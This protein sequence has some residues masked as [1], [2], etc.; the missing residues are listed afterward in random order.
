MTASGMTTKDP[1]Q[2][3][4]GH[5]LLNRF[6][7]SRPL[8]RGGMGDV[9]KAHDRDLGIDIAL[10]LLHPALASAPAQVEFLKNECRLARRLTHPHIVQVY[11]FHRDR[12]TVFISMA[13]VDGCS[14]DDWIRQG[15]RPWD[16]R[17]RPLVPIARALDFVHQQG[18]VHRDVKTGNIL[19]DRTDRSRLTDF[20]IAGVYRIDADPSTRHTGGSQDCMSPQQRRGLP[21]HPA[22]DI[23]S[24]GILLLETLAPGDALANRP[25]GS[26]AFRQALDSLPPA[27]A[28]LTDMIA[29][30]LA[31]RREERPADMVAVA[32]LMEALLADQTRQTI[33]PQATHAAQE[34]VADAPAAP[35]IRPQPF[36]APDT[37][38]K[39]PTPARSWRG[40]V[41][42]GLAALLLVAGG[43][44]LLHYLA[45]NPLVVK[46]SPEARPAAPPAAGTPPPVP[47]ATPEPPAGDEPAAE[48]ALADWRQALGELEAMGGPQWAPEAFAA[49][50]SQAQ[51]AD[52]AF[53]QADYGLAVQ[54]YEAAAEEARRLAATAPQ[55]LT[56]LLAEGQSALEQGDGPRSTEAFGLALKIDP[57]NPVARKGLARAKNVAQV[58]A[59]MQAG[60]D[61]EANGNLALALAD[62][63]A[64][65]ALDPDWAP[66]QAAVPRIRG[67][68]AETQF[69]HHM[70]TGLAAFHRKAYAEARREIKKALAFKPG[71]PEALDAIRQV[72]T[73]AR[74]DRIA[75]LQ[76]Q[77]QEAE[78]GEV[79]D[80]ALRHYG[81]VLAID[82]TIQFAIRGAARA[83]ERL[84][85]EKRVDYYTRR[86]DALSSD[87]YLEQAQQL[88]GELRRV[89][90]QGPRLQSQIATLDRM[91]Q[92][93]QATVSVTVTSDELTEVTIYRIGRLGQFLSRTVELRP[94]TYTITGSRDGYQDVR[95]TIQVRPGQ[96]PIQ[97]VVQC[98]KKI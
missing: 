76:Q 94:G 79:W 56:R 39:A 85:L 13:W 48:D 37:Q 24:F 50:A 95:Q 28:E 69:D 73:A 82:P 74:N 30:M 40:P 52:A 96:G 59:L 51:T 97:V 4:P 36:A 88:L 19:M 29:G 86:P 31:E 12:E 53:L 78:T 16:H 84:R 27:V 26:S 80:R 25:S 34:A 67:R 90:P 49:I 77:A 23:Y 3:R 43:A 18:L 83:E 32:A 98:T 21:P 54:Q 10:K 20:G 70:S 15:E 46:P 87:A 62:Y 22:D 68:V 45:Q 64:A 2:A 89:T 55:V 35:V 71:A 11:D 66:A 75:R 63:E 60:Q 14:F 7:L 61:H 41:F 17:L 58:V 8:G 92:N 65:L 38:D 57:P 9:W 42:L 81:Q 47:V 93:A 33:P 1:L 44:G 5:V 91:V 6:E 72:D